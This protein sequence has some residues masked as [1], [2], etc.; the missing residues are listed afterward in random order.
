MRYHIN[1]TT[2]NPGKCSASEGR[3]PFG[4]ES[5]HYTSPEAAREA[6]EKSQ[7][8]G[9]GAELSLS[10]LNSQAKTTTDPTIIRYAAV[11]GSE[12]TLA[13]LAKNPN[14]TKEQVTLALKRAVSPKLRANLILAGGE[15]T[16]DM[17]PEDF[18]AVLLNV[19][20]NFNSW[21]L[22]NQTTNPLG[23][24]VN[25]PYLTDAHFDAIDANSSIHAHGKRMIVKLLGDRNKMTPARLE[26]WL[27]SANWATYP[28]SPA[29]ALENGKLSENALQNAPS[30]YLDYFGTGVL[31]HRLSDD[32]VAILGRVALHRNHERLQQMVALDPRTDPSVLQTMADRGVELKAVY[33]NTNTPAASKEMIEDKLP[34]ESFVRMGKLKKRIGAGAFDDIITSRAGT[35][36]GRAYSE[37]VQVFDMAKVREYDLSNDDIFYLGNANQYNAGASFNPVTGELTGRVDSSD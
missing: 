34:N 33:E 26:R 18:E 36:I 31:D 29:V 28:V 24:V 37:A 6:F 14:L 11:N 30:K 4:G 10:E 35:Q 20:K 32:K 9:P 16:E 27:Q 17:S 25:S 3:C 2:G 13:N 12:R 7:S 15:P 5:E 8:E 21:H 19:P 1:P 23:K 22:I